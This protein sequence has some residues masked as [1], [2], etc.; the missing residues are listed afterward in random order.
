[1]SITVIKYSITDKTNKLYGS[2]Y[3]NNIQKGNIIQGDM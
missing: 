1:M 3:R 2:N